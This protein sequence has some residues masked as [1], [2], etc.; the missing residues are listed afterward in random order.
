MSSDYMKGV[1]DVARE[2]YKHKLQRRE[3]LPDPLD[4]EVVAWKAA[5]R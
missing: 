3:E 4:R 1:D 2:S 5:T